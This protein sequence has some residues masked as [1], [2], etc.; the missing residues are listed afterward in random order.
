MLA[1]ICTIVIATRQPGEQG[2]GQESG[3][4]WER[5]RQGGM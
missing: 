3:L 1:Q 4:G 2:C 5:S